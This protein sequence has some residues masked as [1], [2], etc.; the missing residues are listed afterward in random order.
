MCEYRRYESP[1][2]NESDSGWS[3]ALRGLHSPPAPIP[4]E[5]GL[6]VSA[7]VETRKMVNYA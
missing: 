5:N 6:S 1:V 4:W 3:P 2:R 7:H